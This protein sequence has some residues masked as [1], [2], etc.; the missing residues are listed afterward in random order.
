MRG[1]SAVEL[2]AATTTS[3]QRQCADDQTRFDTRGCAT[4]KVTSGASAVYRALG[5][6]PTSGDAQRS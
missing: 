6:G 5:R 2:G 4:T 1:V 3:E